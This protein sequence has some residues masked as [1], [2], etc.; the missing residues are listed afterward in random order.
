MYEQIARNKW[1]TW[2]LILVFSGL[3]FALVWFIE[4]L[5]GW[6]KEG[7]VLA[8]LLSVAMTFSSY[9]WS[10]R[11]VLTISRARPLDKREFPF[12]F[13]TVEGLAIAAG[14]PAPAC[15]IIDDSAPNAF[16]TGRSPR[17]A[18]IVVTRGLLEK[19]NR[20]ELEGVIGH[21]MAH[22]KNYDMLLQ[23]VTAV[24]AGTVVLLSDWWRRSLFW[25][26]PKKLGRQKG[27]SGQGQI[28][29]LFFGFL[30]IIL[31]P[32]AAQLI[33][34][35]ISRQREFLADAEGVRLTRYPP[36]LASALRKIA[37]DKETLEA[38]NRAT[39]HLYIVNRFKSWPDRFHRLFLTHPPVEERIA[40]LEKMAGGT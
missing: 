30:L 35:A 12:L 20:L 19:L 31:A 36:G 9:Y 26:G 16:T 32:L 38:A 22:I 1:K 33:R 7:L 11:L 21:E 8:A 34:L 17:R 15:Y 27:G 10:D 24:M 25:R 23:T 18:V 3:I 29:L 37:E 28:I 4:Y 14:I 5:L 6:G 13:H 2:G 40:A 39:A